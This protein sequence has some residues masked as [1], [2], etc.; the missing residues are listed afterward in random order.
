[1]R[2]EPGLGLGG[3]RLGSPGAPAGDL[4]LRAAEH[5]GEAVQ[6]QGKGELGHRV[7]AT[8]RGAGGDEIG[9]GRSDRR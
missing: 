6:E 1:M 2:L 8:P 7:E 9:R 5:Q 3:E 4:G